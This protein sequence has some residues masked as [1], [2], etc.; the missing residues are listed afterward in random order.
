[1][2]SSV[3]RSEEVI[4][5]LRHPNP[6]VS[7]VYPVLIRKKAFAALQVHGLGSSMLV[8]LGPHLPPG[9]ALLYDT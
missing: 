4:L 2:G 9:Q 1:M 3:Q 7:M 8:D 6:G 5:I